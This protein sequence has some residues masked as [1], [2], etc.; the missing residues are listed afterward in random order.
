MRRG[1]LPLFLTWLMAMPV[2][3]FGQLAPSD[4]QIP[5]FKSGVELVTVTAT[6]RDRKGRLVK[7]LTSKD[8]EVYDAGQRRHITEFRSEPSPISIAILFDISGTTFLEHDRLA[9]EPESTTRFLGK[10]ENCTHGHE[11]HPARS[12]R[13][14]VHP[15]GPNARAISIQDQ[16]EVAEGILKL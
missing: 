11:S 6:V 8:F 5:R 10:I 1:L 9:H 7:G 16:I 14:P 4:Q 2:A 12:I 15:R 3:S 13:R